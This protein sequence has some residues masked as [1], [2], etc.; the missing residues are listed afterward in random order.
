MNHSDYSRLFG[1]SLASIFAFVLAFH[2]IA[3]SNASQP[4]ASP[5]WD[6]RVGNSGATQPCLPSEL[7]CP[8]ERAASC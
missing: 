7:F 3:L 4:I 8:N 6:Q 1:L 2:A 5:Q